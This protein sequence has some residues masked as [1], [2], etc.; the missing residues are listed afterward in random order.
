M[1][2]TENLNNPIYKKEYKEVYKLIYSSD[3]DDVNDQSN[4]K[5]KEEYLRN[6]HPLW[7]IIESSILNKRIWVTHSFDEYCITTAQLD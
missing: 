3:L 7:I 5:R 6:I 2:R 1:R 4:W